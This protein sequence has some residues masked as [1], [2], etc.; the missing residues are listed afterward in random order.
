MWRSAFCSIWCALGINW[1]RSSGLVKTI[2]PTDFPVIGLNTEILAFLMLGIFC[3]LLGTCFISFS[4]RLISLREHNTYPLLYGKYRYTLL[5]ASICAVTCFITP[6]MRLYDLSVFNDMLHLDYKKNGWDS[7]NLGFG[8]VVY[9]LCKLFLTGISLS[10]QA[11]AGV[12]YPLMAAGAVFGSLVAY[13][14]GFIFTTSSNGIYAAVGAASLVSATTH[15]IS[16]S[17][18]VF[19]LTGQIHYFLPMII[20]VLAAYSVS[21]FLTISIYDALL[22]IKGL[23]YL[24]SLKPSQLQGLLAKDIMEYSFPQ[25]TL[26]CKLKEL[27]EA[28]DDA[29]VIF[30][31]VPVVDSNN[32][33]LYD[34]KLEKIKQYLMSRASQYITGKDEQV[35]ESI[36]KYLNS[37]LGFAHGSILDDTY[38]T[39]IQETEESEEIKEFLN[40]DADFNDEEIFKEDA[41]FALNETTPLAKVHFLFIMLGFHQVYV[42][43]RGQ[44]VGMI[45]RESF[46]KTRNF[47]NNI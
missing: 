24:P 13:I 25:I 8:L 21:N 47:N 19:E 5:I 6:Y 7:Y 37:V 28:V 30:T 12:L 18:I 33:L 3:G 4:S 31:K 36:K 42:I 2:K 46:S 40:I 11:S 16:V 15:T 27:V 17:V 10:C 1:L 26:N 22:E 14:F 34:I 39:I 45:S 9:F 32:G 41:P 35:S 43:R 23:P 20:S 38:K 44:L 29:G